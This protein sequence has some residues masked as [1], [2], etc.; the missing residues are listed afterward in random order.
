MV[1]EGPGRETAFA[2]VRSP[3]TRVEW[4]TRPSPAPVAITL[5]RLWPIW[6]ALPMALAATTPWPSR[7]QPP[8]AVPLPSPAQTTDVNG[9]NPDG[10]QRPDSHRISIRSDQQ[11]MNEEAGILIARG[12]VRITYPVYRLTATAHHAQYFTRE[13]RLVLNG[14]VEVR[15]NGGNS[16]RGERLVY[17]EQS[18]T[19]VVEAK[20]GEQVHSTYIFPSPPQEA[21]TP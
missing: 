4:I 8:S 16:I 18:R 21:L 15:Q 3:G 17:T 1:K 20:P 6:M 13:G 5:S 14:G 12:R 11:E 10:G 2:L 19:F 9:I 7:A